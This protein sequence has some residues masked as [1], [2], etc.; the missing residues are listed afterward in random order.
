MPRHVVGG[1]GRSRPL[2]PGPC[3]A[4]EQ[5]E[6]SMPLYEYECK[7]CSHRF[8]RTARISEQATKRVR[9][10]SC[11]STSVRQ[12]IGTVSVQTSKKS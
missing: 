8:E 11:G 9:C 5:G 10:P 2:G 4:H 1:L 6:T 12:L 7:K 3:M